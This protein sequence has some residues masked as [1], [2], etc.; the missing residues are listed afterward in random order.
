[1]PLETRPVDSVR[2]MLDLDSQQA[3]AQ[4]HVRQSL[5]DAF[6]LAGYTPIEVPLVEQA[7]LYLRKSGAEI[8]SKMYAFEDFGGRRLALRPELTA[9]IVRYYLSNDQNQPFPLR[10][11]IQRAGVS[12][13]KAPA[14]PLSPVFDGGR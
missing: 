9:S 5:L 6:Q 1:M 7:D 10:Y 4:S 13:R 8:I 11:G 3:S 14:R 2:G 12:L